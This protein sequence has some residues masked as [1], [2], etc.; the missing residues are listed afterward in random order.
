[1]KKLFLFLFFILAQNIFSQNTILKQ[2]YEVSFCGGPQT[3]KLIEYQNG[4]VEGFLKTEL[5]KHKTIGKEKQI[6][7]KSVV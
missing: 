6:D 1:M 2:S 7:R 4:K 3:V 5:T